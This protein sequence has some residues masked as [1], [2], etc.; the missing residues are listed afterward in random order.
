M[1]RFHAQMLAHGKGAAG[2]QLVLDLLQR[3]PLQ[4]VFCASDAS[5]TDFASVQRLLTALYVD[6]DAHLLTPAYGAARAHM[7]DIAQEVRQTV[8][9]RTAHP[10]YRGSL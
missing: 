10:C 9:R 3:N 4:D 5:R 7:R 6:D 1:R 8:P 2:M